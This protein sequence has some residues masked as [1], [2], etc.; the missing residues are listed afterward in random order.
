MPKFS[1]PQYLGPNSVQKGLDIVSWRDPFRVSC[2]FDFVRIEKCFS[3]HLV[4]V[5]EG[6]DS[7]K[8][9]RAG[10]EGE[11]PSAFPLI[12]TI[13]ISVLCV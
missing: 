7:R 9:R 11:I 8:T 10:R 13:C 4:R 2:C 5:R 1:R 3:V 6:K 12:L